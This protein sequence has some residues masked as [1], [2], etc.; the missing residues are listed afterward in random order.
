M[1][2]LIVAMLLCLGLAIAVVALVALPARREG[3]EVLTPR[4]EEVIA[5]LRE[6]R[7]APRG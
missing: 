1:V 4:G 3:R 5:A 7:D 6:R 2:P